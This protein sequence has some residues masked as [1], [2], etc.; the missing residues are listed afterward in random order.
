VQY[1]YQRHVSV[2]LEHERTAPLPRGQTDVRELV[3]TDTLDASHHE[4]GTFRFEGA[5][6]FDWNPG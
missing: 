1:L 3:P 4:Q 2:D 5:V 6:I